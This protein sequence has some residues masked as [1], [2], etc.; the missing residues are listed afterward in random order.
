MS[1][2]N[3]TSD[4]EGGRDE[5][6]RLWDE[7]AGIARETAALL[8]QPDHESA[9][10]AALDVRADALRA[11]INAIQAQRRRPE[12]VELWWGMGSAPN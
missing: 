1:D 12:P 5:L 7:L 2:H 6:E 4:D 10:V 3:S 9:D 8:I 11:R